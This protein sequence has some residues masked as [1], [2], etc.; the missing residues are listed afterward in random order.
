MKNIQQAPPGFLDFL[1]Q[2]DTC[3]VSNAIET[4]NIRMRNEGYTQGIRALFPEMPAVAGYAVTGRIRTGAPPMSHRYYYQNVEWWEFVASIP[5]PKIVVLADV[6][7]APGAGAFFGEIHMQIS[8]ALGCAAYVTN[9]TIR[10]LPEIRSAGFPC[11]ASGVSVS[12]AYA[13]LIEMGEPVEIG[14]LQIRTGDLLHGDCHGVQNVPVEIAAEIP[15][16]VARIAARERE[17][18]QLCN[19]P[20]FSLE[21]LQARL[22]QE[23]SPLRTA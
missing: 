13:H 1:R 3:T 6:D 20:G 8:K 14:C 11:F 18:I 15:N 7:S 17:L 19:D 23:I 2:T 21:R 22:T 5:E 9:G 16:A 4:F 12:H 10:D